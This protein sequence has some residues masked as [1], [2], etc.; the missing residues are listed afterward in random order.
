MR[1][2]FLLSSMGLLAACTAQ[3]QDQIA[4]D[5]ARQVVQP[6]LAERFPGAPVEGP[7]DCIIDN[8]TAEEILSLAADAATGPDAGTVDTIGRIAI[9]SETIDC[10]IDEGLAMAIAG[11]F[12]I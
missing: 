1:T 3:T 9:R 4:Q 8:A 12:T 10:L 11:D 6:M 2:L 5:T 7:T